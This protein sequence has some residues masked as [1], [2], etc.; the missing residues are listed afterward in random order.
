MLFTCGRCGNGLTF[1]HPAPPAVQC[2]YCGCVI[3][4]TP[5]PPPASAYSPPMP[6]PARPIAPPLAPPV[7]GTTATVRPAAVPQPVVIPMPVVDTRTDP[8]PNSQPAP[9]YRS[10]RCLYAATTT[11]VVGAIAVLAGMSFGTGGKQT[12]A[13]P[14]APFK[15]QPNRTGKPKSSKPASS[16]SEI[17]EASKPMP[18]KPQPIFDDEPWREADFVMVNPSHYAVA[19][20]DVGEDQYRLVSKAEADEASLAIESALDA[21]VPIVAR[22]R[23]ERLFCASHMLVPQVRWAQRG[24]LYELD[25]RLIEVDTGQ[26]LWSGQGDR[27]AEGQKQAPEQ[28]GRP[29]ALPSGGKLVAINFHPRAS[30]GKSSHPPQH[31]HTPLHN[32]LFGS[33]TMDSNQVQG[34]PACLVRLLPTTATGMLDVRD[35]FGWRRCT[36]PA[37]A[38]KESK[39]VASLAEVPANEELRYLVW[40][41]AQAVLPP[42]GDIL[43]M[44]GATIKISLGRSDG[45]KPTDRL[46]IVRRGIDGGSEEILSCEPSVSQVDD[47]QSAAVVDTENAAVL[48][49]GD[50]V[51]VKRP[52]RPKIAVFPAQVTVQE[53]KLVRELSILNR[54]Q[55]GRLEQSVTQHG[56]NIAGQLRAGL[57]RLA[58]L[59]I[60]GETLSRLASGRVRSRTPF[61]EDAKRRMARESGASHAVFLTIGPARAAVPCRCQLTMTVVNVENQQIADHFR[62]EL[63]PAQLDRLNLWQP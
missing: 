5:P 58:I 55:R 38:V 23:Y 33:S 14:R 47:E 48:Q 6:P 32:S 51:I 26:V 46:L 25:M 52:L 34:A 42:A 10:R 40:R 24:G 49:P 20:E 61:D 7:V 63:A 17:E 54:K 11:A 36:L 3:A 31:A 12:A 30:S 18:A 4:I 60:E 1:D 28:V 27:F 22:D 2:P 19:L 9:F 16:E 35:L 29:L 37:S 13:R 44:D 59:M 50:M 39:P 15:V 43:S 56:A 41:I 8:A 21:Q 62:F 57:E 53:A 45:I